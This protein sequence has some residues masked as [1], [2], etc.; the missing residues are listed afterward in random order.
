MSQLDS[1]CLLFESVGELVL[2]IVMT[3]AAASLTQEQMGFRLR[4]SY[5][6]F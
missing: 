6:T 4:H 3:D 5:S 2:N 1:V